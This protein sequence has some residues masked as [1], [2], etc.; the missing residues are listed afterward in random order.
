STLFR[1]HAWSSRLSYGTGFFPSTAITEETEAAGLSRLLQPTPLKAERGTSASVDLTHVTGPLSTTLTVFRSRVVHP[2]EVERTEQYVIRNLLNPT[3]NTG[4][5]AL[6]VWAS[7]D[8]SFVASYSYVRSQE[9][10]DGGRLAVPLTP[11]HSLN[12]DAAWES[13]GKWRLGVE[14]YYT[15]AQR[16]E[17]NPYGKESEPY[18]LF[19]V[20]ATRR[21]G[22]L[23]LF[24]NG[25]NLLNVKQTDWNPLLR[26]TRGVDGRW[27]VDAWAPL[28][29]RVLNGGVKVSF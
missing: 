19:G 27:T 8:F 5:E 12:L 14:W 9:D 29:G 26:P 15:G 7:D 23:L 21:V 18:R 10:S 17:A 22:S 16:P 20:L 11:R 4:L 3:T 2:V 6:G 25:E 1:K 28:D 24:V 13:E